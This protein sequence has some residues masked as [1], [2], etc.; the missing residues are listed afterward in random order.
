MSFREINLER[1]SE[2]KY[3]QGISA[4]MIA[5]NS[6]ATIELALQSVRPFVNEMIIINQGS[7]DRTGEIAKKYATHYEERDKPLGFP[8]PDRQYAMDTAKYRWILIVDADEIFTYPL[9]HFISTQFIHQNNYDG[10]RCQNISIFEDRL[11]NVEFC[12][13]Y[14]LVR[15]DNATIRPIL[16]A[17]IEGIKYPYDVREAV[18]LHL[19]GN[20]QKQ[21]EKLEIYD[22]IVA[23]TLNRGII[24][25]EEATTQLGI[26]SKSRGGMKR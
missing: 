25:Q 19:Q 8:E 6:G 13:K 3:P 9:M 7:T 1:L 24:S 23:D 22:K 17:Q 15:K 20:K 2:S 14:V 26:N 16:H 11:P 12:C 18:L 21:L 4:Y 5:Y 10:L